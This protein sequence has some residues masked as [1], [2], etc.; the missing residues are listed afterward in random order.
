MSC[1]G[2]EFLLGFFIIR[3]VV[4]CSG[5]GLWSTYISEVLNVGVSSV[6]LYSSATSNH[7][8]YQLCSRPY[9]VTL[10]DVS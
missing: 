10:I 9:T 5:L 7:P 4:H 2:V 6:S 1:G 3:G 8:R